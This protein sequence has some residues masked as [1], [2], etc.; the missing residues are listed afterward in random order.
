MKILK[1]VCLLV[2]IFMCLLTIKSLA[3][4]SQT[5]NFYVNDYANVLSAETEKYI[6][7]ANIDLQ[8]RTGAQIV[9]VTVKSLDGQSIEE[10]ATAL[11]RKFGIGDATKNNGVLL[12]C[13]TGERLFRIEV[14]YG[15]EGTLTDGKTGRIQD[16]YIIPYLRNNDYDEGIKNGFSAVLQEVGGE[17]GVQINE[18]ETPQVFHTEFNGDAIKELV[19]IAY[20][21]VSFI[22]KHTRT[23]K[24]RVV[25]SGIIM[26]ISCL[27][28]FVVKLKYAIAYGVLCSVLGLIF[29]FSKNKG[30]GYWGGS[31]GGFSGGGFSG[32]GFHG[33]GGSS[34]GGGSTRSF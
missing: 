7:N 9:V 2:I 16:K 15:L 20:L 12:L 17:Y 11:F 33:G 30:S 26:I 6:M 19:F 22:G 10:Y 18:Q 23:W 27:L 24:K 1:R 32:G 5:S 8:K 4:V 21:Y 29:S 31:S 28:Q 25:F 3:I 13:S 34:G 14:G